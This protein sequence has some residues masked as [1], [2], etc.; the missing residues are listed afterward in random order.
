MVFIGLKSGELCRVL[1]D[2]KR[3]GGKDL[4]ALLRHVTDDKLVLWG[5]NPGVGRDPVPL[6]HEQFVAAF[7]TWVQAG[8]PCAAQ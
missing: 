4:A 8:A 5:W 2:E 6:P 1:K 7:R 3:N